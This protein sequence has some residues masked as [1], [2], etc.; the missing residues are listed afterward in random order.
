MNNKLLV[1][2]LALSVLV[3]VFVLAKPTPGG[4][5][6]CKDA[7]DNDND[8]LTDFP[9]DPGCTSKNDATET[10]SSLVCDDG[11]DASNDADSLADYRLS[12]G[13]PGCTS[14]TDSSE[15]DGECDDLSDNDGDSVID[16]PSDGGCG[17]YSDNDE[18]NCEDS[19]CEGGE[20]CDECV[21]DCG[22]CD[23][24]SDTDG[25]NV[26]AVFGTASGYFNNDYFN[27]DD[28]CV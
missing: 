11:A 18:S 5:A 20:V 21:A 9:S 13:D 7:I 1:G 16:Y 8:G 2:I 3:A 23:S 25:G 17:A 4:L 24:C 28:Y 27:A 26:I 6:V 15:I 12:G 19:V 22:H 14:L 10:S